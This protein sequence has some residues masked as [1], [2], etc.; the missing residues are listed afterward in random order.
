MRL[1]LR[2]LINAAALWLTAQVIDAFQ[3]TGDILGI[4]IV[5]VIFGLVNA[6]IRPVVSLLSLPITCL[7]LGLFTL[8]INTIMLLLTDAL[9]GNLLT[10]SSSSPGRLVW[11]FIA[12]ILISLISVILSSVLIEKERK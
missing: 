3:L 7:T 2:I 12:S 5:A 1:I 6:L 10:I 4:L 8:V 9:A 11:A